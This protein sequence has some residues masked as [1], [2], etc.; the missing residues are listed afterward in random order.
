MDT[1]Y[2]HAEDTVCLRAACRPLPPRIE[3]RP[4]LRHAL[5]DTVAQVFAVERER[6]SQPTRGEAPVAR[7][8]QVA[9]YL[10]HVGYGL[11][12]T[13]VGTLFG[14]DRTTV[15]HACRLVEDHREDCRF[16]RAMELL[17]GV[18]RV[19]AGDILHDRTGPA[20]VLL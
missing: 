7:A 13:E 1:Q 20:G 17:E 14:R 6:L 12:L 8:R 11:S 3:P 9:M 15:A 2:L 5:E 19:L 4:G 16:D 10:A 18:V